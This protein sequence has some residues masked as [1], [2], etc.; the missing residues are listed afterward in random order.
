MAER[1]VSTAGAVAHRI[2][3]AVSSGDRP[4]DPAS[5]R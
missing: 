2:R 3:A 4:P 5:P 1:S